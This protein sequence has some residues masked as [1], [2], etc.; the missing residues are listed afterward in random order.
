MFK[1]F[2]EFAMRGNVLDMAVGIIIGAA[3]GKIITS[4]VNDVL[5]PPIG[6]LLGR[7]DFGSLFIDLSGHHYATL[8]LAKAAKA[9]TLNYG[10]FINAVIDFVI[11]A[12][13]IFMLVRQVNRF[14]RQE[15]PPPPPATRDCPFCL[16]AI[17]LKA[18]KC[19]HCTADVRAA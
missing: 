14:R 17:P 13:A 3:F 8:E 9:P 7:I 5:M 10:L 4:F 6:L 1:E 19:P 11:V 2:K 18:T 16:S 15:A 12:F